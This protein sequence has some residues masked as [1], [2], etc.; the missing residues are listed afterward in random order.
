MLEAWLFRGMIWALSCRSVIRVKQHF[1]AC[2]L[3]PC[4]RACAREAMADHHD[5]YS[6]GASCQCRQVSP[7][8]PECFF[9]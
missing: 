3:R 5:A 2:F 6:G 9:G 8:S 4:M 7:L 1:A